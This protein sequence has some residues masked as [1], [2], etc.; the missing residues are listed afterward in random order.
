MR[1]CQLGKDRSYMTGH[2]M[3]FNDALYTVSHFYAATYVSL[4]QAGKY[5]PLVNN[6]AQRGARPN[7][8]II[9]LTETP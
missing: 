5:N 2:I 8:L 9:S 7:I 3:L 1:T 4:S 6:G